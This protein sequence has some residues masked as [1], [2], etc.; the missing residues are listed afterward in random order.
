MYTTFENKEDQFVFWLSFFVYGFQTADP[1]GIIN[2]GYCGIKLNDTL[3]SCFLE[4][5]DRDVSGSTQEEVR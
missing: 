2:M 5:T 3:F 4:L 1:S